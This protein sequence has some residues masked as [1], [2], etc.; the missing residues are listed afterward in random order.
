M[1]P[2]FPVRVT[3][4]TPG[5]PQADPDSGNE[6]PGPVVETVSPAYLAQR[7]VEYVSAALE[8][9][10]GRDTVT[11]LYTILVPPGASITAK[12]VVVDADGFRYEVE[13]DPAPRRSALGGPAI[14]IA[15][16]LRR[17]SDLQEV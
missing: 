17:T 11:S 13:G 8:S 4:R 14:Y 2:R 1:R 3:L 7:P 6:V 5:L 16:A 10:A 12:T 15:A 9:G